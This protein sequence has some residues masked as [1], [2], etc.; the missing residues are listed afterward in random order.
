V[1]ETIGIINETFDNS[2]AYVQSEVMAKNWFSYVKQVFSFIWDII[3]VFWEWI[4]KV[5]DVSEPIIR[6][7]WLFIIFFLLIIWWLI[8]SRR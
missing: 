5:A 8:K 7:K 2:V 4:G 6:Y 1:N 3:K